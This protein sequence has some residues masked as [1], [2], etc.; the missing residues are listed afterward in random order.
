M[1]SQKDNFYDVLRMKLL[2]PLYPNRLVH[3]AVRNDPRPDTD[4]YITSASLFFVGISSEAMLL[5]LV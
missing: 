2:R 3:A 1:T 4:D 5:V